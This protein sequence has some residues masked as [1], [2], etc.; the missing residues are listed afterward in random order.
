[1]IS[2]YGLDAMLVGVQISGLQEGEHAKNGS[3]IFGWVP[4]NGSQT[5]CNV[6]IF[7]FFLRGMLAGTFANTV[8]IFAKLEEVK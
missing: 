4:L 5:F 8:S 2:V 1:M 6:G 7:N 3:S